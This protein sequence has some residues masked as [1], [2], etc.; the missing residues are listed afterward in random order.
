MGYS[1]RSNDTRAVGAQ[2]AGLALGLEH[3]G[4]ADHVV[5]GNTLS[6]GHDEGN[7]G[8]DGLL[9]PG[10]SKR[11]GDE[12]GRGIGARGLAGLLNAGEDGLAKVLG[13]GLLGVGT[14]NDI[15]ALILLSTCCV[16]DYLGRELHT[17]LDGLLGV[18]AAGELASHY[19]R[20]DKGLT[21]VPC[22]PVKPWKRTLVSLL[23]RR[24]TLVE[25]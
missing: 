20:A 13:A 6:D 2:H 8:G 5:L 21:H 23:M 22:L 17:V 24:L 12:D 1:Y 7:L 11:R 25:A 10:G 14:A 18:E 19:Y 16:R 15:R 3:I 9:D 4:D